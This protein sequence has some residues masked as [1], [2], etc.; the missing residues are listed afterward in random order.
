M[1][2]LEAL[3]FMAMVIQIVVVIVGGVLALCWF[4]LIDGHLA[5]SP[6]LV[7]KA[8]R[9]SYILLSVLAIAFIVE[10]LYEINLVCQ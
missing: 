4:R 1:T 8:K 7:K 2:V 5:I 10:L 6:E 9:Y 3:H